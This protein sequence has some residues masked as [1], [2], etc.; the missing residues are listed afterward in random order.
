MSLIE[1]WFRSCA[2]LR[3]VFMDKPISGVVF[4]SVARGEARVDSG[5]DLLVVA[6]GP[7]EI[8]V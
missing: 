4:G 7:A 8:E 5:V 6:R 3:K 2:A 1:A